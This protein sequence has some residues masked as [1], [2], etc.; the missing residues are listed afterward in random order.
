MT[1]TEISILQFFYPVADDKFYRIRPFL[2]S[3]HVVSLSFT[4]ILGVIIYRRYQYL[5]V[6]VPIDNILL[7]VL[8]SF[9]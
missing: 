2:Q 8:C 4:P 3:W 6:K 7:P 9:L 5:L 1:R